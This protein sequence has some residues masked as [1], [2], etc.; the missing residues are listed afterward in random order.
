MPKIDTKSIEH[1]NELVVKVSYRKMICDEE[2][3]TDDYATLIV[4]T[5][6]NLLKV[7]FVEEKPD[8][9]AVLFVRLFKSVN[10]R[11]STKLILHVYYEVRQLNC[12][13]S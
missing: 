13:C 12:L 4:P 5:S 8:E 11:I 3:D 10:S 7:F 2:A 9:V 1:L 6:S